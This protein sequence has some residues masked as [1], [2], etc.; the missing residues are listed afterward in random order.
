MFTFTKLRGKLA[1]AEGNPQNASPGCSTLADALAI[2][3]FE[4]LPLVTMQR[5]LGGQPVEDWSRHA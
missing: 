4:L 2:F 1:T 5:W 3:V